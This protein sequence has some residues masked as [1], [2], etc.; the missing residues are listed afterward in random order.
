MNF[1]TYLLNLEKILM[2]SI[3]IKIVNIIKDKIE[4]KKLFKRYLY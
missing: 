1:K 2:F 3:A 4:Y